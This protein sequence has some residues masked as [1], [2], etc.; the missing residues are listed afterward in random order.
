MYFLGLLTVWLIGAACAKPIK[1]F[2][3]QTIQD[4]YDFIICGGA[5]L[6]SGIFS[7]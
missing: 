5:L 3:R 4:E 1:K 2:K 6:Y 7:Y